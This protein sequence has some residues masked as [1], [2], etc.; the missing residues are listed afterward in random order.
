MKEVHIHYAL[1]PKCG[2]RD[3]ADST[4]PATVIRSRP[5]SHSRQSRPS[6]RQSEKSSHHSRESSQ[7]PTARNFEQQRAST[8]P[9]PM[10]R[11][12]ESPIERQVDIPNRPM[13]PQW[14]QRAATPPKQLPN[15]R[16]SPQQAQVGSVFTE[17]EA[18]RF[19]EEWLRPRSREKSSSPPWSRAGSPPQSPPQRQARATATDSRASKNVRPHVITNSEN[20]MPKH[21]RSPF[22]EVSRPRTE[23]DERVSINKDGSP[24][25]LIPECPKP[26]ITRRSTY[27]PPNFSSRPLR[28]GD[29][30]PSSAPTYFQ[31]E[32]YRDTPA[33]D[34]SSQS[35]MGPSGSFFKPAPVQANKKIVVNKVQQRSYSPEHRGP[36]S[37]PPGEMAGRQPGEFWQGAKIPPI[38]SKAEESQGR[39]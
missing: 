18:A 31:D 5:S 21:L 38:K 33:L 9:R 4:A 17:A 13:S 8:P 39:C 37:P 29:I 35:A 20:F 12:K 34:A 27:Q 10:A 28:V 2:W 19:Q 25:D 11:E 26:G 7:R 3:V 32:L 15:S 23:V 6:S 24:G 16:L 36:P 14:M 30:S 1:C 22:M